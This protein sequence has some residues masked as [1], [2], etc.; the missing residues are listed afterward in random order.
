MQDSTL[1][2]LIEI[3]KRLLKTACFALLFFIPLFYKANDLFYLLA[4]PLLAHLHGPMIAISITAPLLVPIELAA[5]IAC[6]LTTPYLLYQLW[7]FINPAL[8]HHET[9]MIRRLYAASI[10]LFILG[11]VF[12]YF[13]VLPL[14]FGFFTQATPENVQL[15]PDISYYLS[16]TTGFFL[17]FGCTFQ[18][19]VIIYFLIQTNLV[20]RDQLKQ[21]RPYVIVASFT[22][23]ML[24]TPPDVLS[25]LLLAIPM[26]LLFELGLFT[27]PNPKKNKLA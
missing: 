22:L 10:G 23:G 26:C 25:Q 5:K 14:L 12:C 8:Y 7:S 15:L 27:S 20:T 17:L 24:F 1:A 2:Y 3:R 11:L 6:L 16:L 9:H 4:K 13:I 19:P 21:A 18:I